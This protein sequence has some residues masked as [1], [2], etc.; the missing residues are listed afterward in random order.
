MKKFL[1]L[2][3]SLLMLFGTCQTAFAQATVLGEPVGITNADGVLLVTDKSDNVIYQIENGKASVYSGRMAAEDI[4]GDAMEYYYDGGV[5]TA[6]YGDP[7]DII[8]F[9][10]GFAVTDTAFNVVR[11][12]SEAK[13]YT[14]VGSG[15]AGY[16]NGE[17][18]KAV[19]NGPT[20]LA[21]DDAGNLYIADTQNNVIRKMDSEGNVTTFAGSGKE[22][23]QDGSASAAAFCQPT[24]ID[25]YN[26][27]LY[28][29]DTGNQRI[30]KV[31]NG[32]VSTFAGTAGH[33]LDS[34]SV[35]EGGYRDGAAAQAQFADPMGILVQGGVVY[36]ADSGN[37]AVRKIEKGMVSTV[38]KAEDTTNSIYPSQPSGLTMLDGTLYITDP[39]AGL[40]Y[41]V[42]DALSKATSVGDGI[43]IF[44]DVKDTDWFSKAVT[45]MWSKGLISGTAEGQFSPNVNMTRGMFVTVVGRICEAEG[46]KIKNDGCQFTDVKDDIYY[47]KYVQWAKENGIASGSDDG[48][49]YPEKNI[50]R[51][52]MLVMLRNLAKHMDKNIT[53]KGGKSAKDF[54][55]YGQIELWAETAV[56]W[57]YQN[58]IVSGR[59]GNLMAPKATATRAEVSQIFMK[60]LQNL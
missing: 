24:D 14:L 13:V 17:S 45:F 53:V 10:N 36:V 59:D 33:Y 16:Q 44:R 20:G 29:C 34:D 25:W 2:S 18:I 1:A 43:Q 35:Y 32:K 38:V 58:V 37:S 31:E 49:F 4:Y 6:Y 22:G 12:I 39:F 54:A 30:R 60:Y 40:V 55:D 47:A 46:E 50:S 26:G 28:V 9:L 51:Q 23:Y 48:R 41:T 19:F 15:E 3:M 11:Y 56:S 57:A 7:W 21:A 5:S 27:A 8:P 52:E 42:Q